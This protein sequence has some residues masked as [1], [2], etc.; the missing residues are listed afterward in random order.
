VAALQLSGGTIRVPASDADFLLRCIHIPGRTRRPCAG[1]A[2][3]K[4]FVPEGAGPAGDV[5]LN[6]VKDTKNRSTRTRPERLASTAPPPPWT[7]ATLRRLYT[8]R[9]DPS[10]PVA[11]EFRFRRNYQRW[12]RR[13]VDDGLPEISTG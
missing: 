11:G 1:K 5:N 8:K 3:A 7:Q 13:F 10:W 6:L 4:P 9:M 2:L 12:A